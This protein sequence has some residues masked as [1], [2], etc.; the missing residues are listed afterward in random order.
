MN[1]RTTYI[2]LGTV[3]V[4]LA[5]LGIFVLTSS[6][7]KTNPSVEGALLKS[8]RAAEVKAEAVGEV[9]IERAGQ[10]KIVFVREDKRWVMTAP[11]KARIDSRTVESLVEGLLKAQTE[12]S[13]DI[14]PNLAVHG[15]ENP[16]VKVTLKAGS[17]SETLSLGNVTIG[18]DK[19]VVYVTTADRPDKA[20]AAKR[21]DLAPLFKTDVKG[22]TSAGELVK[23]VSDFRPLKV[24]GEGIAGPADQV[25]RDVVV[26][27]SKDT[28]ALFRNLGTWKFRKPDDFGDA[29]GEALESKDGAGGI[30]SVSQLINTI[31]NIQPAN[32]SQIIDAGG[33]YAKY[34]VDPKND[35]LQIDLV[36][37]DGVK[38]TA[39]ISGPIKTEGQP[40]KY[41]A[42]H[43][44]DNVVY[45]VPGEPVKK[46]LAALA[47]KSALRD[48]TVLKLQPQRIDAID[49]DTGTEKVELRRVGLAWQVYDT[50]GKGRPAKAFAIQE[51]L[52]RLNGT[53]LAVSFPPPGVPDDKMGFTKPSMEVK[54]WENG[55]PP[56]PK[57]DAAAKP[58]IT[59]PPTAR[60]LFGITDVGN[61]VL[62]R[63]LLVDAK[64]DFHVSNDVLTLLKKGRLDYIDASLKPYTPNQI[65]KL[66]FTHD[67]EVFELERPDDGK[68]PA[69]STWTINSPERIKGRAVDPNKI[70]E[71]VNHLTF[72]RPSR[73]A[74]DRVTEDVLNRLQVKP[75]A[76]KLKL[77]FTVKGE[78][79]KTYYFGGDV[80]IEKKSVYLKPSDQELVFEVDRLG[81]DQFLKADVQDTIVH[82]IDKTKIKA[83][84]I[85][86][87]QEVLGAP[88]VLEIER[89][90]GK[91]TLKAKTFELDPIK[92]DAFLDDLTA[93]R[94]DAFII[95]KEGPKPEHN[96]EVA[97]NA[98]VIEMTMETGSPVTMTISPPNKEGKVFATT[99][100]LKG[101]VFTM[102]DR[103]GLVRSK[104][105]ALKKD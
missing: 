104:P 54:I 76:S 14:S 99:S 82:R 23:S 18:A 47:N 86:G 89:L 6:D 51:L 31:M 40:D 59:A 72:L 38:E 37:E 101:D 1:F 13:A 42:K 79:E 81:F 9:E 66:S 105:A 64:A 46:V 11:T 90:D 29:A 95:F 80:G 35:P 68:P 2:L 87:W 16:P 63:R 83:V 69:Q 32:R 93:P 34:G 50:E 52:G 21:T 85:T 102:T 96:L 78:G 19:A 27:T 55:V 36:R 97:K 20:Q 24:L 49:I 12:K 91:W 5:V 45:E 28:L 30:N 56:D 10:P 22:A 73:V 15:L 60:L 67:K 88:A 17:T 41:Y 53:P 62:V 44:A 43:E 39:V 48:R 7:K 61:V 98:L 3:I 70:S 103:F 57:A 58:S 100:L 75:D 8:F 71:L 94:A 4:A 65:L 77:T 92:V 33:D 26:R 25:V 74:S 84:K